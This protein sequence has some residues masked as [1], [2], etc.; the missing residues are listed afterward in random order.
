MMVY[1]P[2]M[3]CKIIILAKKSVKQ[4]CRDAVKEKIAKE[5]LRE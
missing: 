1:I 2:D 5:G 4:F 3:E